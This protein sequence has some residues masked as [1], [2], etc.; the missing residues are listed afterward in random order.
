M[1]PE[2]TT[3]LLAMLKDIYI[4]LW[5]MRTLLALISGGVLFFAA[6]HK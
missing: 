2:Q 3:Q 4:E 1:T 6:T 5:I